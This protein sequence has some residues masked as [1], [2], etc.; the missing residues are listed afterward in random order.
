[1]YGDDVDEKDTQSSA[2][3]KPLVSVIVTG[4]DCGT[5]VALTDSTAGG[6][7]GTATDADV[8]PPGAGFVTV[9]CADVPEIRAAGTV[10]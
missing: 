5:D 2:P 1:M 7:T 10:A 8:P 4:V 3:P 9:T 6:S